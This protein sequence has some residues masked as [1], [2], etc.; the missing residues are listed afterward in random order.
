MQFLLAPRSL[1]N[2]SHL[3][4][5]STPSFFLSFFLKIKLKLIKDTFHQI[6]RPVTLKFINS[7]SCNYSIKNIFVYANKEEVEERLM[8]EFE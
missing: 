8:H 7:I 4:I 1:Q 5:K 3:T 6:E 2:I